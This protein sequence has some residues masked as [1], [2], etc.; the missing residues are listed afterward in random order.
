[1]ANDASVTVQ[2]TVLPDEI[3]KTIGGSIT[4][5]P[6]AADNAKWYYKKTEVQTTAADLIAGSFLDYTAVDQ[7]TAPTAIATGDKVKFL[8]VKNLSTADGIMISLDGTNNEAAQTNTKGIHVGA[9]EVVCFRPNDTTVGEIHAISADLD[10]AG[11]A[12]VTCIVAALIE[13]V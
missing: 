6:S 7:D 2:A 1:M 4:V 10:D 12:A 3:A 9:S 13:D 11:D 8:F 5:D